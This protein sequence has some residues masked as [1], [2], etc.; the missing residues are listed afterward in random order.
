MVEARAKSADPKALAI[1]RVE[2]LAPFP[3][4]DVE[5]QVQKYKNAE[6]VWY[7]CISSLV[8]SLLIHRC[9]EEHKNHGAWHFV[10]FNFKTVFK[11]AGDSRNIRYVGTFTFLNGFFVSYSLGR[12]T[13]ASPATGSS[14]QHKKELAVMLE[15][16]VSND[17][18]RE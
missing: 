18:N 14:R 1:V 10:Y 3:F 4:D 6:I 17:Y 2:Q 9:Q 7:V 15:E 5:R 16:A 11:H 13:A 8:D 12:A